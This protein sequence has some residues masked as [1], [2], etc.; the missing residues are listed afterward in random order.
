[1]EGVQ[2]F[3]EAEYREAIKTG[4]WV[5]DFWA[6]WCGPCRMMAPH[7]AEAAKTTQSAKFGKI[8]V[9]EFAKV[10]QDLNIM[11]IPCLVY[12]KDGKEVH[13]TVGLLGKEQIL[14]NV[15]LAFT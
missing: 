10:A 8:N 11:G 1:M 12:F 5:I 13:R 4:T 15:E 9:Q 2:E 3:T 14:H 6:P 7:F